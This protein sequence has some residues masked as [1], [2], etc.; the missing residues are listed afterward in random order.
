ML[1]E[2]PFNV[3][4]FLLLKR[5]W[6]IYL[7][8]KISVINLSLPCMCR[9][10]RGLGS[11]KL[12]IGIGS[13]GQDEIE[14]HREA[15]MMNWET[16]AQ[17][18]PKEINGVPIDAAIITSEENCRYIS[19]FHASARVVVVNKRYCVFSD[20][21]SLWGSSTYAGKRLQSCSVSKT[22]QKY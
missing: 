18:M 12:F 3:Y 15:I 4:V 6:K 5:I 13:S 1:Y 8:W 10:N 14:S 7:L 9:A 17:T 11:R 19:G 2:M 21:F 22:G 16:L 20:R